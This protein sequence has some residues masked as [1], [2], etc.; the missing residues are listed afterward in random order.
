VEL[1]DVH[2][3]MYQAR[4]LLRAIGTDLNDDMMVGINRIQDELFEC[5]QGTR[6]QQKL[7]FNETQQIVMRTLAR[8]A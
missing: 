1:D 5:Y 4:I 3:D 7:T 2:F 8:C 6:R